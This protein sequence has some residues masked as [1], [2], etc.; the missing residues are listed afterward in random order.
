[1]Q[2]LTGLDSAFL[3]METRTV[4]GHVGSVCIVDPSTAPEPVTL[5]RI[6]KV[7]Q[8]RLPL[9]PAFRRRLV[10]VPLGLDFPYWIDDPDFDIEF[11]VRE[12]ALTAPGNARQ[13]KEQV[14]RL[15]AR[16]LDRTRPLWEIYLILGLEGGR[17]AIYTKVHHSAIDG[18]SG[19][20]I[21]AA[22]L[23]LSPE[24]RDISGAEPFLPERPP[25]PLGLLALSAFSLPRNPVRAVRVSAGLLRAAP[26]LLWTSAPRLPVVNRLVHRD[27]GALLPRQPG[28][29]APHSPFNAP[30]TQHRRWA[31]CDVSLDAVKAVKNAVGVTVND[32]VLAL[33]AGILR[34]WLLDHEALPDGPLIAA[35]PVSV[36]TE[37]EKGTLGNKVSAM[38]TV[39]PTNLA[40]PL[41]RLHAAHE[42]TR[43]AKEQHGAIPAGLLADVTQFAMPALA[44]QAAR[45]SARLRLVERVSLFNLI[46]SNVPG[47]NVPL[48]YAGAELLAYYPLSAIAD[49]QG[50]NI[51][52][53]S[54]RGTVF[55]GLLA[56]RELVPDLD[57]MAES[58]GDEMRDLRQAA[59][60]AAD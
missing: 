41:D 55:F 12:L 49:G 39:L 42:A 7:I 20:E 15:H 40:D 45:L 23:D 43:V 51:T 60:T 18:V 57:H 14:A 52:V 5:E 2:Q 59:G 26:T 19:N 22:V 21:L 54:Y 34:R 27:S 1:M 46:I 38:L 32:V 10:E 4:Y 13:L 6:C 36:R 3:A 50:L 31:F 56:C 33:A 16:P 48:Y 8:S 30:I 47:P 11:H 35:V 25:G 9:V 29:R 24:G 44:G 37:A 28:L 53:L 58:I 17:A